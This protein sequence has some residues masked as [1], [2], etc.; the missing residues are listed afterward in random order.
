MGVLLDTCHISYISSVWERGS[1]IRRIVL[2][3]KTRL[4]PYVTAQTLGASCKTWSLCLSP[5]FQRLKEY[6]TISWII[7]KKLD[8]TASAAFSELAWH[9]F[10]GFFYDNNWNKFRACIA[11]IT[12][13]IKQV[14]KRTR[15]VPKLVPLVFR[16]AEPGNDINLRW[17]KSC[18]VGCLGIDKGNGLQGGIVF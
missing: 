17:R 2:K 7:S 3:R 4:K 13:E 18:K 12:I 16:R 8:K 1:G 11:P 9:R 6:V 5:V 14:N 15:L 10:L